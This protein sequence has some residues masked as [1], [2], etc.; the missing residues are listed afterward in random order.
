M[1]ENGQPNKNDMEKK[2]K[3]RN[4]LTK[5]GSTRLNEVWDKLKKPFNFCW[6]AGLA[7]IGLTIAVD[8][9]GEGWEWFRD[10]AGMEHY[11]WRD[12]YLGNSIEVRHFSNNTCATFDEATGKRVSPRV[13]WISGVPERDSLTMFSDK[14]GNRGF[15]NVN[16]GMV[17]IKGQYKHA[18]HFSEGL[19]AVVGED[20]KVGFINHDN[21]MVIPAVYEYVE[22]HDYVFRNGNCIIKDPLTGLFGA[23][24]TL[25]NPKL[26]MEYTIIFDDYDTEGMLYLRKGGKCGLADASLNV[27]FEPEYDNVA[28]SLVNDGAYLTRD[29]VKQLV[30]F[31]G[32]VI[33]PFVVDE[34]WPLKYI[35]RSNDV[36]ADEYEMHPYL[37]EVMVDYCCRGVMDARTGRMVIPAI[38]TDIS[39][40]SKDLLM[41]ELDGE[42]ETNLIFNAEGTRVE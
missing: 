26:P 37:V 4:F 23:I 18:W 7:V 15:I 27:V 30:S 34:I 20:G 25:G 1:Y 5:V 2:S 13:R 19:A 32:E 36:E 40:I 12:E 21:Q 8:L 24:D 39:M 42:E 11:Y 6:K 9:I 29:G 38:Y 10:V 33:H 17:E 22:D 14:K 35:V 3:L 31:T 28:V 41:A 16:T